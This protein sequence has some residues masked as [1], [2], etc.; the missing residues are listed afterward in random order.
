M[1]YAAALLAALSPISSVLKVKVC[2]HRA[3]LH[4]PG[5]PGQRYA[6]QLQ[7]AQELPACCQTAAISDIYLQLWS[8]SPRMIDRYYKKQPASVSFARQ[9]RVFLPFVLGIVHCSRPC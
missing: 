6:Q 8:L 9:A 2:K 5:H 4:E 3:C 1:A 7:A